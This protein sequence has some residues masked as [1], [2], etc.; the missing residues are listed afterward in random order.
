MISA[1]DLISAIKQRK[2]PHFQQRLSSVTRFTAETQ[3]IA[4]IT[5]RL[6]A[7]SQQE[8]CRWRPVRHPSGREKERP[9][10]SESALSG[11]EFCQNSPPLVRSFP[12]AAPAVQCP[13]L[14]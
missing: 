5:Q 3:R 13:A 8:R 4:G 7:S 2:Y 12:C 1:N 11:R 14:S 10:W 9:A 6:A